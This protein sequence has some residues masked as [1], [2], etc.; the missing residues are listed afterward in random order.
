VII[1]KFDLDSHFLEVADLLP[2]GLAAVPLGDILVAV[3]E[4]F[5]ATFGTLRLDE[6][7]WFAV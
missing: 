5:P 4:V 6:L 1:I 3:V 7:P 2:S